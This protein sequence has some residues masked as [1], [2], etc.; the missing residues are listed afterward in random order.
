M[1]GTDKKVYQE[2]VV[3]KENGEVITHK[4]VYKTND[5]PEYIKLYIDTVFTFKG[6]RKGLN[7]IFLAFLKHMSYA[8]AD[9]L[10]GGQIIFVNMTMKKMIA[11]QLGLGIDSIN[12]ALSEFVKAGVFSR[13]SVGTYQ[14]NPDIV[15]KGNWADI[16]NIRATFDF[17]NGTVK[18]DVVRSEEQSMTEHQQALEDEFQTSMF[19]N[20][21]EAV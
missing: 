14:V 2:V 5:E 15:G 4:T 6:L 13:V 17:G 10:Y 18:A 19:D 7:P 16:K 8:G 3:D 1:L 9:E 11:S 20:Q 12:K 21:S